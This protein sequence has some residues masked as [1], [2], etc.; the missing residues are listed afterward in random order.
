M[1]LSH[2]LPTCDYPKAADKNQHGL[3]SLPKHIESVDW[4]KIEKFRSPHFIPKLLNDLS[5]VQ[6]LEMAEM[7]ARSFAKNE[8]MQRHIHPP[9]EKPHTID[10]IKHIDPF[11]SDEFGEWSTTN[12][13]YWIIRLF[14]LT[15]PSDPIDKIGIH[16]DL[17]TL[18]LI[19]F[20]NHS[21]IV[22]GA[23]NTTVQTD[24][25]PNRESDPFM[26]A[27]FIANKPVFELI[28]QQE[29]EAISALKSH[30]PAFREAL[31]NQKVG[32]H[33]L[34]AGSPDLPVEDTFELVAA[35]AE[36]FKKEGFEF[37]LV[38]AMNQW[39]GAA[40]EVLNGIRVHFVPYRVKRR[41][42]KSKDALPTETYSIDGYISDKDSGAMFYLVKLN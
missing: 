12:I 31:K 33:F 34:I 17:K 32:S 4:N 25:K 24:D 35:S 38:G 1:R 29:H 5:N 41:V 8:P 2:K 3:Y 20:G 21:K 9:K 16:K 39:T 26:D 36:V 18:S 23:Y 13:I 22:G 15:N 28:F 27:V 40:C 42:P 11:G 19:T 37:M 7:I 14:I 30:Y 10:N 6:I